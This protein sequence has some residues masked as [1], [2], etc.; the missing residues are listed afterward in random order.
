MCRSPPPRRSRG[1]RGRFT[2]HRGAARHGAQPHVP[3]A[4]D[5]AME[6]QQLRADA[7]RSEKTKVLTAIKPLS[8]ETLA[9]QKW[10]RPVRRRQ[11]RRPRRP[12][13]P[14]RTGRDA[15]QQHRAYVAD[16]A[17]RST[18]SAGPACRST[19]GPASGW[20]SGAPRSPSISSRHPT[21]CSAHAGRRVTPNLMVVH[22]S[23][24]RASR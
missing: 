2:G 4:G 15:G 22:V 18:I 21:P 16:A 14:R 7:V 8:A 11:D 1:D 12:G 6:R 5:D 19:S 10:S 9:R 23:R 13:I 24:A 3:A 20:R 17:V